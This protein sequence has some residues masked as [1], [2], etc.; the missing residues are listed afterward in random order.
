MAWFSI[1]FWV[2]RGY[3]LA[4]SR[5]RFLTSQGKLKEGYSKSLHELRYI[6]IHLHV[7]IQMRGLWCFHTSACIY[8]LSLPNCTYTAL[9]NLLPDA[10]FLCI[11]FCY[12]VFY[13]GIRTWNYLYLHIYKIQTYLRGMS[14]SAGLAPCRRGFDRSLVYVRF[15]VTQGQF[16]FPSKVFQF[17]NLPELHTGIFNI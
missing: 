7:W 14:Y 3:I 10:L 17:Y 1:V 6:I 16:L 2:F 12:S 4:F 15:L 8:I 9:R 11:S 5:H 13:V